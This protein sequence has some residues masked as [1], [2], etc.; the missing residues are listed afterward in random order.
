MKSLSDLEKL[1]NNFRDVNSKAN[2][3]ELS[4]KLNLQAALPAADN[5]QIRFSVISDSFYFVKLFAGLS[6]N[7]RSHIIPCKLFHLTT[8]SS[9]RYHHVRSFLKKLNRNNVLDV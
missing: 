8:N 7:Q 3:E 9:P 4:L 2:P 1:T 6:M 5:N